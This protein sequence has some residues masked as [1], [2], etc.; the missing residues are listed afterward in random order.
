M[1]YKKISGF[2][3]E[4]MDQWIQGSMKNELPTV[5]IITHNQAIAPMADRLIRI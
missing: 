1:D 2:D 5:V 3:A 4:N